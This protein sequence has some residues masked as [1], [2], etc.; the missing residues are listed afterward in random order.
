MTV[1]ESYI[2]I[3]GFIR[4]AR[5]AGWTDKRIFHVLTGGR[6]CNKNQCNTLTCVRLSSK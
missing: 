6:E 2:D 4:A 1:I 5:R 3:E